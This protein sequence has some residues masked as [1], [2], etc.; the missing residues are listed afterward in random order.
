MKHDE[1][2]GFAGSSVSTVLT[3]TQTNEVFQTVQLIFSILAFV[4]TIAYT[5]WKWYKKAKQ[6][7]KITPEEV[8]ELFDN[9]K[10]NIKENDEN[11]QH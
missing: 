5:V 11:E 9:L 7:G 3:I 2:V 1:I 4:V 10:N 6:D 8:E